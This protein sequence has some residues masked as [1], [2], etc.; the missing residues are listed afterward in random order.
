M[1]TKQSKK[2]SKKYQAGS[3][4]AGHVKATGILGV[5]AS[6]RTI[7]FIFIAMALALAIGAGAAIFAGDAFQNSGDPNEDNFVD[8][9][10]QTPDTE[11]TPLDEV[12]FEPRQ[13]TAPPPMTIDEGATYTATI[14]TELGDITVELLSDQAPETVN[15]FV[16]L[17]EDGFY[18]G[19]LF[20]YVQPEFSAQAGDPT[21]S[22]EA[23]EGVCRQDGGP[24][25]DLD[26][27]V[28]GEFTAGTLGMV[29]GSQFF[30]ALTESNQFDQS[31]PFARV[32]SGLDV[33]EQLVAN[34][35][36]ESIEI[37]QS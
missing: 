14:S 33:A 6:G 1:S 20:H 18:D 5:L 32:T 24:G 25:Y 26:E 23:P 22:V 13:F 11:A 12:D 28:S 27:Q 9:R 2:R 19:L 30:I 3:A 8:Q 7:K 37:S 31:T 10:N 16:F 29:N 15:N 17:A 4:Y 36:I 34:T 21:C 35:P